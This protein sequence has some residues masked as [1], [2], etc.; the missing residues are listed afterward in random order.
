MRSSC[1]VS[2]FRNFAVCVFCVWSKPTARSAAAT[3]RQGGPLHKVVSVT[4][5]QTINDAT[6]EAFRKQ[7]N[8]AANAL[9]SNVGSAGAQRAPLRYVKDASGWKIGGY[10]GGGDTQ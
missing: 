3:T 4:P 1:L 5:P 10:I 8:E 7:M 6:F 9:P 2:S